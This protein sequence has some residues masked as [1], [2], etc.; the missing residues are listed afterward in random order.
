MKP[1]IDVSTH[2]QFIN[3]ALQPTPK[4]LHNVLPNLSNDGV[5]PCSPEA[6]AHQRELAR[7]TCKDDLVS[8]GGKVISVA[9]LTDRCIDWILLRFIGPSH[10]GDIQCAIA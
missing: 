6:H 3:I 7:C 5:P 10:I 2:S 1:L 9:D 8:P 4:L